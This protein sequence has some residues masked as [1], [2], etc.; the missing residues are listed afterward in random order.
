MNT[1][2]KLLVAGS[3]LVI[4][5]LLL[6]AYWTY[7]T[8]RVVLGLDTKV[9]AIEAIQ[10]LRLFRQMLGLE[11]DCRSEYDMGMRPYDRLWA[12]ETGQDYYGSGSE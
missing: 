4:V 7:D 6:I 2:T 8:R 9:D 5:L 3:A 12:E 10:S 11:G 1:Q